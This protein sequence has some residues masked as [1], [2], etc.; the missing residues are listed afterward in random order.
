MFTY[1]FMMWGLIYYI[2]PFVAIGILWKIYI[3]IHDLKDKI[4]DLESKLISKI[5]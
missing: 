5:D 4:D 2:M 1:Y 3:N